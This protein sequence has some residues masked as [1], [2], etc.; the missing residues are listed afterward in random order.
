MSTVR[1]YSCGCVPHVEEFCKEAD[2]R[3]WEERDAVMDWSGMY[4]EPSP[5][6]EVQAER[7]MAEARAWLIEHY[8]S[9]DVQELFR[10]VEEAEPDD[11]GYEDDYDDPKVIGGLS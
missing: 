1:L 2:K 10:D 6:Q 5:E 7:S 9:Q 4:G 11:Y 8:R 3:V